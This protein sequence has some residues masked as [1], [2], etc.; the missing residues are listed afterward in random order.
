ML[1]VRLFCMPEAENPPAELLSDVVFGHQI[2]V[3]R[4]E[5][6]QR[7]LLHTVLNAP[8]EFVASRLLVAAKTGKYF[9]HSL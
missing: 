7:Q 9:V 4:F 8:D 1:E 2:V 5:F 3:E 6:G